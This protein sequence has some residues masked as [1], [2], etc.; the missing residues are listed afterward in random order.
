MNTIKTGILLSIIAILGLSGCVEPKVP[1]SENIQGA[2]VP[3]ILESYGFCLPLLGLPTLGVFIIPYLEGRGVISFQ[4]DLIGG[5]IVMFLLPFAIATLFVIV[6]PLTSPK[7]IA[8]FFITIVIQFGLVFKL[9]PPT[10]ETEMIGMAQRYR[11]EFS[12]AQL[13]SCAADLLQ[14]ERK[15][16][17]TLTNLHAGNLSDMIWHNARVVLNPPLPPNL[18]GKFLQVLI[19]APSR[20]GTIELPWRDRGDVVEFVLAQ[21]RGILCT[22]N[23]IENGF[24]TW[25]LAD[26]VYAY[27]WMRP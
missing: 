5:A 15:G 16:M 1:V 3:Q 11:H 22:T 17:L 27:R 19:E 4:S 2:T 10:A 9:V 12:A 14:K 25:Q 23:H 18:R 6:A 21:D 8:L 20:E 24:W 7:R 13:Q 26:G